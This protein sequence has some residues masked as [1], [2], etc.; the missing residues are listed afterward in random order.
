MSDIGLNL[1]GIIALFVFLLAAGLLAI[2][3]LVSLVVAAV[4]GSKSGQKTR[5]QG[6]FAFFLAGLPFIAV[7]LIAFGI[8]VYFVDSNERETNEFL[9]RMAAYV[10]LPLQVIFWI[11]S[12][13]ILKRVR[14]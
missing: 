2:G 10:W 14:R 7:N 3:G 9:D 13:I 12:G 5:Q 4:K 1:S 8:L 6:A 11:G